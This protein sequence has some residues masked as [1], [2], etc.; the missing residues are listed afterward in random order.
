MDVNTAVAAVAA[1]AGVCTGVI[2]MLAFR[3]SERE[4]RRPTRSSLHS[5]PVLPPGVDTVLSA[6]RSSAVVLD[7]GDGVVKASSAAYALGLVRGGKLA[8]ESMLKMARDTRRDGEIRQAELDL[9]RRGAGRGD[10]L[11]VSARVAPL[12]SRLVLL[13][14][15]DLTEARRIEA[16]RRD[17]VAN[18]S[19][20][21]KTPVGALS[22][23]S[24][25]VRDAADDPEAVERFA[26]RMEIE[27][28]RLTSLV[29][30][31]IDLSRV[32]NDDPM[33]DAEPVDVDELIA[34]AMDRSRQAAAHKQIT[35]SWG[36]DIDLFV[37]GSRGALV[38]ALGNLVENAVNYSPPRTRVGVAA[39]RVA[40][41]DGTYIDITVTD[42]GIGISEKDRER[43][44]ERFY[45][46]DPARS[47]ATGGTGLGLAI[48]KHVAASHGG[49]VTVWSSEGQGSTFTL[50]L[51]EA[52]A[53]RDRRT[54]PKARPRPATGGPETSGA[55]AARTTGDVSVPLTAP[56]SVLPAPE[57]L[58]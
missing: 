56:P 41:P 49:E 9:P 3:W 6:L 47:R 1:I 42:Q 45:R 7:E 43:I 13:L 54:R 55:T 4:L 17:F 38:G 21:L 16:V 24:E 14:V 10:G 51:P 53:T 40:E 26:G 46:V 52:G 30:E 28:T 58:P 34:E 19:H 8:V 23:L 5:T 11:A 35:M 25:A 33:E 44:F 29:Q 20:E 15:E 39:R 36:G 37:W 31:L 48:V 50:R 22:L 32:Q 57:V 2:A 12:G 18:V 27:A